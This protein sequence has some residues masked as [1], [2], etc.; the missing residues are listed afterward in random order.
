MNVT[1]ELTKLLTDFDKA[2]S[3]DSRNKPDSSPWALIHL[4]G[5]RRVLRAYNVARE[6]WVI[7]KM[8]NTSKINLTINEKNKLEAQYI[9]QFETT[10]KEW[11]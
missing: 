3:A 1:E 4:S 2:A 7:E 11:L 8:Q 5:M 6:L 9:E 10:I